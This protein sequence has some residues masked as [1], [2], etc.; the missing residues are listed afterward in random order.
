MG[1]LENLGK[2]VQ[3]QQRRTEDR[4]SNLQ[5]QQVR[6]YKNKVKPYTTS[7]NA[8][9]RAKA[10]AA[11]QKAQRAEAQI[12]REK[13]ERERQRAMQDA[14]EKESYYSCSSDEEIDDFDEDD[15]PTM[16]QMSEMLTNEGCESVL[17]II[18]EYERGQ[19]NEFVE[20]L[21]L[22]SDACYIIDSTI[23]PTLDDDMVKSVC[24][25]YAED[26][27]LVLNTIDEMRKMLGR[28]CD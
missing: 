20:Q 17:S 6:E 3:N 27:S 22:L 16:Q 2:A 11:M 8:Q 14:L 7:S 4:I 12:Q 5:R 28:K 23:L 21:N 15:I 13:Y 25:E 9:T 19:M 24:S 26:F 10:E 18:N 1:F